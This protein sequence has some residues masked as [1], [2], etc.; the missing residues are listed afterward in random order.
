MEPHPLGQ[1]GLGQDALL[2][3][4]VQCSAGTRAPA[5][6][7]AGAGWK[8]TGTTGASRPDF[9]LSSGF[10]LFFFLF[11]FFLVDWACKRIFSLCNKQGFYEMPHIWWSPQRVQCVPCK[12]TWWRFALLVLS[13]LSSVMG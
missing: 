1:A 13:R 5:K 8:G 3:G 11:S 6:G 7:D 2:Q 4:M 10:F 12:G 9:T